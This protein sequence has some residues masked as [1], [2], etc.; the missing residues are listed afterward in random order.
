MT[1]G[2]AAG[3]KSPVSLG[4]PFSN[5]TS[6]SGPWIAVWVPASNKPE[7]SV[8]GLPVLTGA[9]SP[10]STYWPTA[11]MIWL[12]ASAPRVAGAPAFAFWIP[13]RV[14]LTFAETDFLLGLEPPSLRTKKM[15]AASTSRPTA[16]PTTT[17]C[18]VRERC[19][20][21]GFDPDA[22]AEGARGDRVGLD[23]GRQDATPEA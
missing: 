3:L 10:L 8:G 17:S 9:I 2:S 22:A 13:P 12:A 21:G 19:E 14:S 16:T 4:W 20:P 7:T 1:T 6:L 15:T 5:S 23:M 18:I 11:A